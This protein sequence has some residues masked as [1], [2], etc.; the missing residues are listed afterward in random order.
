MSPE[1]SSEGVGRSRAAIVCATDFSPDAAKGSDV[2]AALAARL[3]AP[4]HLVHAVDESGCERLAPPCDDVRDRLHAEAERLRGRGVLVQEHVLYG[5]ADAALVSHADRAA[6][7]LIV[8]SPAG[9]GTAAG[10]CPVSLAEHAARVPVLVARDAAPLLAW[11][12]G[13]RRLRVMV[14]ADYSSS[15][16]IAIRW[17]AELRALGPCDVV[18][19]YSSWPPAERRRLGTGIR[20]T[21][22]E[23][24]P[25]IETEL[26][27]DLERRV[28]ALAGDGEVRV[29]VE[30]CLGRVSKH[31]VDMAVDEGVDVLIV[32]AHHPHGPSRP[33]HE[34][35]SQGVL[36][37]APMNVLCAPAGTTPAPPALTRGIG[38]VLVATDLS[39]VGNRAVPMV[40][41]LLS[42]GGTVHLMHVVEMARVNE[43]R[44]RHY[45]TGFPPTDAQ[46]AVQEPELTTRLRALVPEEAS[47]R[48][49]DTQVHIVEAR[50]AVAAIGMAAERLGVDLICLGSPGHS[51]LSA[52]LAGS[53]SQRLIA[54]SG[55]PVLIVG[56]GER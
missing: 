2:A 33:W 51:G 54:R 12:A 48:G 35:V 15:A 44:Y 9:Q 28:S 23:N 53:A 6:A 49:I 1:P 30:T 39:E 21:V 42:H 34:S 17:I 7:R 11:A 27:L 25:Q 19:A 16:A 37:Q 4:L 18:V 29:R 13:R 40:C 46:R 8:V 10:P 41:A 55:R 38:S 50:D 47:A 26:Q 20:W 52:V 14:A 56:R 36:Q 32:G 22:F 5:A 24:E 31:L 43:L 3:A 45:Q